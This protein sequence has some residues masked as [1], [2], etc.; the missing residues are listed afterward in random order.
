MRLLPI[1]LRILASILMTDEQSLNH[2]YVAGISHMQR[3]VRE[4]RTV[5]TQK[6]E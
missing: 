2:S 4:C 3:Y 5:A 1:L 6:V